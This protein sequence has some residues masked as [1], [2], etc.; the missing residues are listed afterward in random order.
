MFYGKAR[1]VLWKGEVVSYTT[2]K[3]FRYI[4]FGHSCNPGKKNKQEYNRALR[5]GKLRLYD[6]K[7]SQWKK[8]PCADTWQWC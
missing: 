5:N 2:R 6:F 1:P 8:A 3:S 7:N 4:E